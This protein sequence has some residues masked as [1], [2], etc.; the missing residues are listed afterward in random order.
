[1]TTHCR[2]SCSE[3]VRRAVAVHSAWMP[4]RRAV[5]VQSA[6]TPVR[7]PLAS[8]ML[9]CRCANLVRGVTGQCRPA[10]SEKPLLS[11]RRCVRHR[12][13]RF[14][15]GA[16]VTRGEDATWSILVGS[17]CEHDDESD[18]ASSSVPVGCRSEGSS[19][20]ALVGDRRD[21]AS[22]LVRSRDDAPVSI[23]PGPVAAAMR[24]RPL[25]L[26]VSAAMRRRPLCLRVV[27]QGVVVHDAWMLLRQYVIAPCARTSSQ[28]LC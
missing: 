20:S 13:R 5:A 21:D 26:D 15:L 11:V 17:R 6:W 19:P 4:V 25:R 8:S 2:P 1:V 28:S 27:R 10:A 23:V 7:K 18:D 12:R 16:V 22:V 3:P 14:W 9:G 24:R